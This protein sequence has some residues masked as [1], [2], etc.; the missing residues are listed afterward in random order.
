[1]GAL[2][3]RT[4]AAVALLCFFVAAAAAACGTRGGPGYRGP[5][6]KCVGWAAIGRVCG[7][8]PSLRCT[9]EHAQPEAPD[10]AKRGNDIQQFKDDAHQRNQKRRGP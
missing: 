4:A 5:D 6:G 1:M 2:F 8:P 9:A 10:A 7:D 3:L